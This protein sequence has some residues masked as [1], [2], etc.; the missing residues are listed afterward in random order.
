MNLEDFESILE[1]GEGIAIEFKRCGNLPEDVLPEVRRH[2]FHFRGD[3]RGFDLCIF[4]FHAHYSIE[5][6]GEVN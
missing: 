5:N 3:G 1:R 6:A 2:G 4:L